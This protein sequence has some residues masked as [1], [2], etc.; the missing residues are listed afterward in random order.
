MEQQSGEIFVTYFKALRREYALVSALQGKLE[1][2]QEGSQVSTQNWLARF[3]QANALQ[4]PGMASVEGDP[5]HSAC[6]CFVDQHLRA[7]CGVH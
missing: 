1:L 5:H 3:R 6:P 2:P 7:G 4:P